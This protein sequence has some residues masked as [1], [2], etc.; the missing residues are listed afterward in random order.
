MPTLARMLWRTAIVTTILGGACA[1]PP[2]DESPTLG[3][4]IEESTSALSTC[5]WGGGASRTLGYINSD[6]M[7]DI[8]SPNGG[9]INQYIATGS[10]QFTFR[11]S[12]PAVTNVWGASN[13]TWLRDF[14]GDGREDL[15]SA[16]AGNLY[17]KIANDTGFSSSTWT[18]PNVWGT[19]GY[20]W[21]GNFTSDNKADI[22]T[23]VGGTIYLF[24]STGSGFQMITS[25]V[26]N[27]WGGSN[28]TWAADF[29]GDGILDIGSA[30]G[31]NMLMK[32]GSGSGHFTSAVWPVTNA[33]GSSS[34][35]WAADFDGNG[36]KDVASA[37]AGNVYVKLSTGSSFVST[38]W[39]V[40]NQWGDVGNGGGNGPADLNG[41]GMEDLFSIASFSSNLVYVKLANGWGFNSQTWHVDSAAPWGDSTWV[42]DFTGDGKQDIATFFTSTCQGKLYESTGSG[43]VTHYF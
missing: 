32:V 42:G 19:S 22:A 29:T 5:G 30:S 31:G 24:S 28:Y 40:A 8:V 6:R 43:F 26:T 9:V 23:A 1:P 21:A 39:T 36:M 11:F 34:Y 17:M 2:E 10:P 14:T 13:Y 12:S 7:V 27:S 3:H 35:T 15:A 41:D 25:N 18:V 33:W 38:V 16:S 20:S 37:V 4:G